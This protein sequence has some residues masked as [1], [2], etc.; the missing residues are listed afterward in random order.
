MD[1]LHPTD[2]S[3]P[4][5]ILY[6]PGRLGDL[7]QILHKHKLSNPLLVTDRGSRDLTFIA[8]TISL[9]ESNGLS[10]AVFS[11]ISP[12]P[13]DSEVDAGKRA[14]ERNE[15]DCVIAIGGGS[16]MD[17]GKAISLIAGHDIPL[18]DFDYDLP[19][20]PPSQGFPPL[21]C[22]PTTAGTGAETESTAMITD[23]KRGVK[24]CIW[25]ED[26]TPIAAILDPEL[27]LGL[28]PNLTAWTGCDALVHAIEAYVINDFHPMCDGAALE[29]MRLI[30]PSL[31][32]AVNEPDNLQARGDM[33]VGS[34]LAGVSF[35]KGLGLVHAIS[36]MVGAEYDTHHGLTNAI[37]L[38]TVLRFN[39]S[40][41]TDK[42]PEMNH[43]LGIASKNFNGFYDAVCALLDDLNIPKTL[44]DIGVDDGRVAQLAAKAINDAAAGTNPRTASI[45]DLENLIEE[46][47]LSGR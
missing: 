21:V 8:S 10:T 31:R 47:I 42:V 27:T 43:A 25:H 20:A 13:V 23:T 38:P 9:L 37:V 7:P 32:I 34:C 44:R 33:L 5:P 40:A 2:W 39:E 22:V 36:H 1:S 18:W 16:A 45:P 14:F 17:G 28:P 4:V 19:S 29:A 6:G 26:Q 15:H 41:I 35:L 12:N 24:G 30:G 3:F 46:A 11:E